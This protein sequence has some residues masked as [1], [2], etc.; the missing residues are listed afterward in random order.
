MPD[1]KTA[2]RTITKDQWE[3]E[4]LERFGADK[5]KWKF[6]CPCCGHITSVDDWFKAGASEGEIAFSCVGR[7]VKDA[8]EAFGKGPGPCNYAGGGL[9]KLNP[10]TVVNGDNSHAMFEFA[11]KETT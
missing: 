1:R 2:D 4:G 5:M 8:R 6:V 3:A 10:V 11:P 7:H 9:F